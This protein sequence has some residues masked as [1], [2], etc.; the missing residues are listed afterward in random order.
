MRRTIAAALLA[1][2]AGLT[3]TGCGEGGGSEI[4]GEVSYD[5]QP[6]DAGAIVFVA[7]GERGRSGGG[8][9]LNGRYQVAGDQKLAPGTYRVEF[10]WLKKNGKK[11]KTD[12]GELLDD[13]AEGLPDKY[14]LKSELKAEVKAGKNTIDFKLPK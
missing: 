9:I 4:E 5:G 10:H 6:V 13:A 8:T 11:F 1:A 2:L 14:H 7:Q 12:A 3:V